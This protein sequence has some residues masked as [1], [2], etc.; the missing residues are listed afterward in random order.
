MVE[1]AALFPN[2]ERDTV[3]TMVQVLHRLKSSGMLYNVNDT[4]EEVFDDHRET[5]FY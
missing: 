4:R 1:S 2:G 5:G 3:D